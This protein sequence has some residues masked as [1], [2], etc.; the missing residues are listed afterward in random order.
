MSD[1]IKI[2][3]RDVEVRRREYICR[4][5]M[6]RFN[7]VYTSQKR[8]IQEEQELAAIQI[9]YQKQ[10]ESVQEFKDKGVITDQ[11][12]KDTVSKIHVENIKNQMATRTSIP[13]KYFYWAIWKIIIKHGIWPFR[14]PF[15]SYRH[16]TK[17]IENDEAIEIVKYIGEKIM[18]YPTTI[19]AELDKKK[20]N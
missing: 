18:R 2:G 10:L 8:K 19:D 20:V 6:K 12:Y 15:R 4:L 9:V 5:I 14:Q 16:M 17:E 7:E 11:E 1:Q 3:G 13:T